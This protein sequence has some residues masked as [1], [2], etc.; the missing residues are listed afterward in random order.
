MLRTKNV[1]YLVISPT[2]D[3]ITDA[4][5]ALYVKRLSGQALSD[6]EIL[7]QPAHPQE[8]TWNLARIWTLAK[9]KQSSTLAIGPIVTTKAVLLALLA[10]TASLAHATPRQTF[11]PFKKE[12][13]LIVYQTDGVGKALQQIETDLSSDDSSKS[14]NK[15]SPER[16]ALTKNLRKDADQQKKAGGL[17][18][19][20]WLMDC[21]RLHNAS[22][23]RQVLIPKVRSS[24]R[25]REKPK[26][27]PCLCHK[28]MRPNF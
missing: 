6:E 28:P 7:A 12:L 18:R 8:N 3:K 21:A 11:V 17:T 14:K 20:S 15:L 1:S 25:T 26:R 9:E 13:P 27:Q 10:F 22:K 16:K 23:I 24:R 19:R 4:D 2:V 5:R